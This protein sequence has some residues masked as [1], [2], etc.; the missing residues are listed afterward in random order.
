MSNQIEEMCL[1]IHPSVVIRHHE[2]VLAK[3]LRISADG[4]DKLPIGTGTETIFHA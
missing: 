4:K 3:L 2:A 1:P